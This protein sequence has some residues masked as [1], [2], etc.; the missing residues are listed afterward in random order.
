MVC[1]DSISE[2]VV[3]SIKLDLFGAITGYEAG[4]RCCPYMTRKTREN[5]QE[6]GHR[7]IKYERTRKHT[8]RPTIEDETTWR[9]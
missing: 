9:R 1:I 2:L 8:K 7:G 5:G 4:L 6:N 3:G